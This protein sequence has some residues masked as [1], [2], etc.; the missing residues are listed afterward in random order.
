MPISK[1]IN[2]I[3]EVIIKTGYAKYDK[4]IPYKI[5]IV[6]TNFKSGSGDYEDKPELQD[7]QYGIFYEIK[8][9]PPPDSVCSI[10]ESGHTSL[11][12]A[13]SRVEE[14]TGGIEWEK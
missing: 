8:F 4:T 10:I 3:T 1:P 2:T 5:E 9:Y 13:I 11:E 12:S 14:C 6:E 7:D